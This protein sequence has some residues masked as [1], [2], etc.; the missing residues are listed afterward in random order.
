MHVFLLAKMV[1]ICKKRES[2]LLL[3]LCICHVQRITK[4]K[5]GLSYSR[6]Y[7]YRFW[8]QASGNINILSHSIQ[9]T[10]YASFLFSCI[11]FLPQCEALLSLQIPLLLPHWAT[12]KWELIARHFRLGTKKGTQQPLLWPSLPKGGYWNDG[13]KM[14]MRFCGK[15]CFQGSLLSCE[16]VI[17]CW[18]LSDSWPS[19]LSFVC[20]AL[21]ERPRRPKML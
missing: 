17:V 21:N 5:K 6:N 14:M 19:S 4:K 12:R 10:V 3:A 8:H 1:P 13:V 16:A 9:S 2:A 7:E 18:H 15:M 20:K 11:L